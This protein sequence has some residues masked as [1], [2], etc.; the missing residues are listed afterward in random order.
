MTHLLRIIKKNA[1]IADTYHKVCLEVTHHG[2]Y[3]DTPTLFTEVGSTKDEWNKKEPAKIIAKSLLESL[4]K[5]LTEDTT[6]LVGIGGGHYAPRFTDLVFQ[7][8]VAFGHMIPKYQIKEDGIEGEMIKKALDATPDAKG[9]YIHRKSF[10]KSQAKA[11]KNWCEERN[12]NIISSK[13]L[14]DL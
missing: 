5:D 13:D 14:E 2:P 7:K 4:E 8:K 1:K 6:I 11:Y 10:K 9:V 12:I 3:L